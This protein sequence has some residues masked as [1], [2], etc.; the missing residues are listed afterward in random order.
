MTSNNYFEIPYGF[1]GL[2][3]FILPEVTNNC[4]A[5]MNVDGKSNS[6]SETCQKLC[7]CNKPK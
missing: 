3:G 4:A 1:K 5:L 6:A 7:P 2:K